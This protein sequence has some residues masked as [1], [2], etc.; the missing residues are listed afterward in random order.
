MANYLIEMVPYRSVGFV[1][2]GD[3]E[4]WNS[5][6]PRVPQV[7]HEVGGRV[8][9]R[10]G[11]RDPRL[12]AGSYGVGAMAMAWDEF[13]ESGIPADFVAQPFVTLDSDMHPRAVLVV[14]A[15]PEP[16]AVVDG[17]L[18]APTGRGY[19]PCRVEGLIA[20]VDEAELWI[21]PVFKF[22]G[23]AAVAGKEGA[24]GA[25]GNAA[26][27]QVFPFLM[28]ATRAGLGW[29]GSVGFALGLAYGFSAPAAFVG[30]DTSNMIDFSL[31]LGARWGTFLKSANPK[32]MK[33]G[34][35]AVRAGS[36]LLREIRGTVRSTQ[37]LVSAASRF[38]NSE[39]GVNLAKSI[40]GLGLL[41]TGGTTYTTIDIPVG[42]AGAELAVFASFGSIKAVDAA[43]VD[44]YLKSIGTNPFG[45]S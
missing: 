14:R 39:A 7:L 19:R 1:V 25:L 38:V 37:A 5:T 33:T 43:S 45:A 6:M 12:S 4:R 8:R 13:V 24:V 20:K 29:G 40:A 27:G 11:V 34:V 30:T 28:T 44:S 2:Y 36:A 9:R 35:A 21:G 22:G 26:T 16:G 23:V 3:L 10:D 17:W 42:G 31:A 18:L 41:D 32:A 15:L